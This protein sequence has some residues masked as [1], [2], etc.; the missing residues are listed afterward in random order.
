M[1]ADKPFL[2]IDDRKIGENF[3]PY[4]IA[5]M[6]A[7]H[8]GSLDNA[9]QIIRAAKKCGADA[10]KLQTYTADTLT[11]DI[12]HEDFIIKGGLWDGKRLYQL[13]QEAQMPWDWNDELF[14]LAKEEKIT[15]FSSP[16]DKS[17][18][19]LLE[20]L[21]VPA[22]KIASF[23]SV[24]IPLIKYV[25]QTG[26]PMIISTGMIDEFEISDAVEAAISAG[27]K[28]LAL[29][30]CVSSYPAKP[31]EYNLKT[32]KDIGKRFNCVVGLS[33]HTLSNTTAISSIS[34]GASIIEK[35]FTLDRSN[36]G[37]DD[38]FSL[39]PNDLLELCKETNVAWNAIGRVDYGLKSGEIGN[40]KFKRS[41]YFVKAKKAGDKITTECIR[42]IRPGYGIEP[43]Y[44]DF[45]VGNRV[46]EDVEYGSPVLE[47][48]LE[49]KIK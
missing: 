49:K 11:L 4:I 36:G 28:E 18:V 1:N 24:D 3:P 46:I 33:D 37:P 44:T 12:D 25:A 13:Y 7:N 45:V 39:E 29:L 20:D 31:E 26:K 19:D 34:L 23:E 17:A 6:S 5:E 32:I 41:L 47:K 16:F 15:I 21:D 42:S 40:D 9:K 2:R 14:K 48:L 35:H 38:S 27:C 30:H 8:N 43:K 10:I 22:Y